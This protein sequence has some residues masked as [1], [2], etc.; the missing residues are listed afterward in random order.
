MTTLNI[1]DAGISASN[2]AEAG[3]IFISPASYKLGDSAQAHSNSDVDIHGTLIHSGTISYVEV[4]SSSVAT[5]VFDIPDYV[6][7]S[8]GLDI[9]EVGI[10]L[11]GDI[12]YARAVLTTPFKK[13]SGK[14]ARVR[15]LLTTTSCNLTTIDVTI[16]D[17]SNVPSAAFVYNLPNPT[18]SEHN[19]VSVLD[20]HHNPDGTISPGLAMRYGA[21]GSS[22]S[23]MGYDR[24][25]AQSMTTVSPTS[26]SKA[27]LAT[28]LD[29]ADN[30][31]FIVQAIS[32]TSAPEV[33]K[34]HYNQT[35]DNFQEH[36]GQPFSNLSTGTVLAIWK[37]VEGNGAAPAP[38]E[39]PTTTNIPPDWVLTRGPSGNPTWAPPVECN[40]SLNTLYEE[41][42]SLNFTTINLV[43]ND[44]DRRFSLGGLKP[45][46]PNYVYAAL[47][48]VTQ[49]RSAF[50]LVPGEVEFA[51]II[52]SNVVVDLCVMTKSVSDGTRINIEV[53]QHT[54]DGSTLR[55]AVSQPIESADY[56]WVFI[57]G[58]KQAL[59]S[60]T[61]DSNTQE[62]VFV[63]PP[64][65][66]VSFE[67]YSFAKQPDPKYSTKIHTT[68]IY[69]EDNTTVL[70]LPIAPQNKNMVLISQQGTHIHSNLYT[71]A[72]NLISLSGMISKGREVEIIVFDNV[73]AEGSP[74]T[75]LTGI[76]TDA[77]TTS[78]ALYMLRHSTYPIKLPIPGVALESGDGIRIEGVH[79]NYKIVNT[80]AEANAKTKPENYTVNRQLEDSEE[81]VVTQ[82]VPVT[83]NM[84]VT[85]M[86]D[87]MAE[88]G[89]GFVTELGLEHMQF[90]VGYRVDGQF[91][92]PEYGRRIKGTG[93]AGFNALIAENA[94][95]QKAYS[96][97]SINQTFD[98]KKTNF[99]TGY[100]DIVAKMRLKETSVNLYNSFLNINMNIVTTPK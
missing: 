20:M 7:N 99:T 78:K 77:F 60:Y 39:L 73:K 30:E 81:I 50:D 22:W 69:T 59:I 55:F 51:E 92:E 49:H 86:A 80:I 40:G 64:Y 47:G 58:G 65:V 53:D 9:Y 89:P 32:G 85:V 6:G 48:S 38:D 66:G 71:L 44:K 36:D 79:P 41:P 91:V 5:F 82:R 93:Q 56:A 45:S 29:A 11:P 75:N 83:D 96:N 74:Q 1:T 61:Y 26:F 8:G 67:I 37:A 35:G 63:E 87:F 15:A 98:I 88:L 10:F 57:A 43:G 62:I 76:V 3:G 31:V 42:S 13:F 14:R 27:G 46:N 72:N 19:V 12:M 2:N 18:T 94:V 68:T 100:M 17:Y 97:A 90:V 54:G 24:V 23:F 25:T 95:N 70:E 34:F 33:R 84:I 4:Q 52:P 16:G 21:G 28:T